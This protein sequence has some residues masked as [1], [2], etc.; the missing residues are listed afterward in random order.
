MSDDR[1]LYD[2]LAALRARCPVAKVRTARGRDAWLVLGDVQ[3]RAGL[4]DPRL[5]VQG[6]RPP[7]RVG[8]RRA[9]EISLTRYEGAMHTRIR[10][11]ARVALS[12]HTV[13]RYAARLSE[14]AEG[15][16]ARLPRG[17]PV[18]LMSQ[19]AHPFVFSVVAEVFGIDA[20]VHPTLYR[21]FLEIFD[22]T[23]ESAQRL[24]ANIDLVEAV[25]RQELAARRERPRADAFDTDA[26][27]MLLRAW[28]ADGDL[29]E[30]ELVALAA[31]LLTAGFDS[32]AQS[33]GMSV[34]ALLDRPTL[35]RDMRE[36]PHQWP[37]VLE[38][39]LRWDTPGPFSS[40]RYAL[41]DVEL[42]GVTIPCGSRVI[43]SFAAA[44]RD[45]ET[46]ARPDELD[47]DRPRTAR[48]LT[49]GLGPHTC[50]G[51]ALARLELTRALR[52]L[53]AA[54]PDLRLAVPRASLIWP[55]DA[56]PRRLAALPV[57][58]T[59]IPGPNHRS[60]DAEPG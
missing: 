30:D 32:T 13:R 4:L 26:L 19:F 23:G 22:Q 40:P 9:T 29:V 8:Q 6:E 56:K 58:F 53:V 49:F 59:D 33:I 38:E 52:A 55:E 50:P 25:V 10:A 15:L 43:F 39:L 14:L 31:M 54:A 51:A 11:L 45:A 1:H 28:Q 35:L 48:H 3:V 7:S 12:A 60:S 44:N 47:P 46:F 57:V 27:D 18:E 17:R 16:L 5:S 2:S 21:A 20:A 34:V 41:S 36:R 37:Q 24:D 42:G